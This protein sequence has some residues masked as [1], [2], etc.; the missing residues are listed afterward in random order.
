[1][2][3]CVGEE[4]GSCAYWKEPPN[5]SLKTTYAQVKELIK[6]LREISI[7]AVKELLNKNKNILDGFMPRIL[8][9]S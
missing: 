6:L 1:M 9:I 5:A 8:F 7:S 2:I 3:S 4:G